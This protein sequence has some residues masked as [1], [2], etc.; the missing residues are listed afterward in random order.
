MP[1][2]VLFNAWTMP[3]QNPKIY[4]LDR[5]PI[6]LPAAEIERFKKKFRKL[7]AALPIGSACCAVTRTASIDGQYKNPAGPYHCTSW[8]QNGAAGF[9]FQKANIDSRNIPHQLHAEE[10]V[11]VKNYAATGHQHM[12]LDAMLIDIEPCY[13]NR[14]PGHC[15]TDFFKT[16]R[17]LTINGV[18]L[19]FRFY[20]K[21]GHDYT[22]IYY[23]TDQPEK[24]EKA[25]AQGWKPKD[26][27]LYR[28]KLLSL[29]G[30]PPGIQLI[31]LGKSKHVK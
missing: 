26:L 29:A 16:G 30:P 13:D 18:P 10:D 17:N 1:Q 5:N 2:F 12:V 3:E 8:P 21:P 27:Q 23:L 7:A 14:Y 31:P 20:P 24:N 25:G 9:V 15:C 28:E 22:P 4:D 11:L 6:T 19:H